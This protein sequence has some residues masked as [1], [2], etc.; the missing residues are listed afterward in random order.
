MGLGT[1]S[2]PSEICLGLLST[3]PLLGSEG[4]FSAVP[5][6]Q[7]NVLTAPLHG[8]LHCFHPHEEFSFNSSCNMSCEEG[9]LLYGTDSTQCTSIGVWT[10]PPPF[11][12]GNYCPTH[13]FTLAQS[14]SNLHHILVGIHIQELIIWVQHYSSCRQNNLCCATTWFCSR[15]TQIIG[16]QSG[17]VNTVAFW[18]WDF[19][20]LACY[21]EKVIITGIK[22]K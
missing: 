20:L 12:L 2:H 4:L 8:S 6:Q 11:C 18:G 7:C 1:V 17:S 3:T 14:E 16:V 13:I 10:E 9:F 5:A 22:L 21:F 19:P 15:N